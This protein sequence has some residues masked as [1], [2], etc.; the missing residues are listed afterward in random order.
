M[1]YFVQKDSLVKFYKHA[2][3]YPGHHVNGVLLGKNIKGSITIEDSIPLFHTR[4]SLSPMMEIALQIV[5]KEAIKRNLEI[6]GYYFT[7][8]STETNLSTHQTIF[9]KFKKNNEA[10]LCLSIVNEK[11]PQIFSN[12]DDIKYE[13]EYS[14][15]ELRKLDL[16]TFIDFETSLDS[17]PQ[18]PFF[19]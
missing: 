10:S 6:V 7:T 4:H 14:K 17:D 16:T 3:M 12:H 11:W 2:I 13:H 8:D 9:S 15:E 18:V 5:E 1:V 19:N